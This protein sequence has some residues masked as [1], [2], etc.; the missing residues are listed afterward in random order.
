MFK[1]KD[2]LKKNHYKGFDKKARVF[3]IACLSITCVSTAVL[4]PLTTS[5]QA[6]NVNLTNS[7]IRQVEKTEHKYVLQNID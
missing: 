6:K 3:L 7:P 5:I 1:M 4:V 2:K